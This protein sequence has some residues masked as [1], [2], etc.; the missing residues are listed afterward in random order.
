MIAIAGYVM[1]GRGEG[2]STATV[3]LSPPAAV[4]IDGRSVGSGSDVTLTIPDDGQSHEVVLRAEGY[5]VV[6]R[7]VRRAGELGDSVTL[8]PVPLVPPPPPTTVEGATQD[9]PPPSSAVAEPPPTTIAAPPPT[10]HP[11]IRRPPRTTTAPPSTRGD[12]DDLRT[13]R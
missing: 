7:S 9:V 3:H 1:V 2:S 6:T 8:V 11:V 13:T 4:T 5:A 10:G 12:D